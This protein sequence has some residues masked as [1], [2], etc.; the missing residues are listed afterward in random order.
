MRAMP[1]VTR[2][3]HE[4]TIFANIDLPN[5][6]ELASQWNAHGIGLYRSEF[7]YMK[8]SPNLPSE[9]DHLETYREITTKMAPFPVT[10]RTFDLGGKKLAREVIGA[11]EA[12]PVLG[13]RG[14]RL[15]FSQPDFLQD[16]A[17]GPRAARR[18][19]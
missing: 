13:L 10:I 16:P 6:V 1:S 14:I 19:I 17:S 3:G 11:S 8:M 9:K 18:R 4:I 15:C 7:L 5:E 2:D 12:N